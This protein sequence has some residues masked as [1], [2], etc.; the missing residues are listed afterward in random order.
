VLC[1]DC[2]FIRLSYYGQ[3]LEHLVL[4]YRLMPY[5]TTVCSLLLLLLYILV[6]PHFPS[7]T[8]RRQ[9]LAGFVATPSPRRRQPAHA[10]TSVTKSVPQIS[11]CAVIY[12]STIVHHQLASTASS[13]T[14]RDSY[15][16]AGTFWANKMKEGM[17]TVELQVRW[18]HHSVPYR[19]QSA[20]LAL[21]HTQEALYGCQLSVCECRPTWQVPLSLTLS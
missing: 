5:K 16:Q 6:L 9:M 14:S 1:F 15:K 18:M 17:D 12:A 11:D 13:S 3:L 21:R 4:P 20:Q 2:V 7:T 19:Q 8:I 10:A